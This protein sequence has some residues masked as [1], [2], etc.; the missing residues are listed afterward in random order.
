MSG[1]KG[2]L[3]QTRARFLFFLW[4]YSLMAGHQVFTLGTEGS[5]PLSVTKVRWPSLVRRWPV[6]PVIKGSNPLRT[7]KEEWQSLVYRGILLRC[8]V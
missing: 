7:A 8:W 4:R 3:Q 5:N 1:G 6:E 2:T